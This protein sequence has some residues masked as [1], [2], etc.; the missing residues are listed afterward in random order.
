MKT[1]QC[2]NNVISYI[3]VKIKSFEQVR[4]KKKHTQKMKDI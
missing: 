2:Q 1:I 4:N 3:R